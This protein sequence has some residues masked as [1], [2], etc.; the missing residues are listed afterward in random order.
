MGEERVINIGKVEA[1]IEKIE[2]NPD[3]IKGVNDELAKFWGTLGID[4][5]DGERQYLVTQLASKPEN[6]W[7]AGCGNVIC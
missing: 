4:L 2:A 3:L 1:A 6:R 5:N 7:N